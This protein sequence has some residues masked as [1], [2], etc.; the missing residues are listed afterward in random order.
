M[1]KGQYSSP[2]FS[3]LLNTGM[4][5]TID[6]N[7]PDTLV[8]FLDLHSQGLLPT[9]LSDP[10]L[11]IDN[12]VDNS[13]IIQVGDLNATFARDF[14]FNSPPPRGTDRENYRPRA[15]LQPEAIGSLV[16]WD[17]IDLDLYRRVIAYDLPNY[18]GA[19]IPLRHNLNI[20]LWR[21]LLEGYWELDLVDFLDYGFPIGYISNEIPSATLHNHGSAT[22]HGQHVTNY[23]AKELSFGALGGGFTAP[24]FT[25]LAVSPLMTRE[26]KNSTERRVVVDLSFP[27]GHS[28]NAGVEKNWLEGVERKVRL[29]GADD[30]A[31]QMLI[32]GQ[33]SLFW[34]ADLARC[35]RQ[36]KVSPEE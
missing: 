3:Q 34:S 36:L 9:D 13:K 11:D 17:D 26:K 16:G 10:K 5:N 1:F 24:P 6:P 20:K 15:L 30:L 12:R 32:N 28:V 18:L 23:I 14:I 29:P 8:H 35:Y 31:E 19:R 4:D 2:D 33:G 27:P 22:R 7:E 21:R 25:W